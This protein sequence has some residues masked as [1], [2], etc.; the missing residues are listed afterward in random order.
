MDQAQ[1]AFLVARLDGF[2]ALTLA[3]RAATLVRLE[4]VSAH[5]LA[6]YPR[7]IDGLVGPGRDEISVGFLP[8]HSF[9]PVYHLRLNGHLQVAEILVGNLAALAQLSPAGIH[10]PPVETLQVA[11]IYHT[12]THKVTHFDF[13]PIQFQW[14][15]RRKQ[16]TIAD[17]AALSWNFARL[18]ARS[19]AERGL[20]LGLAIAANAS[21]AIIFHPSL[22]KRHFPTGRTY[23][24]LIR[25][26]TNQLK[27]N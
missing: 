5:P 8:V 19:T 4:P 26:T 9:S 7:A 22:V 12:H 27:L 16:L 17:W 6:R 11:V 21:C 10:C 20:A 25:Y 23:A 3:Y 24:A 18:E 15:E 13:L 1:R 14:K 2:A